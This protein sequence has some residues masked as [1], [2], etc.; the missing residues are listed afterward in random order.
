MYTST[1]LLFPCLQADIVDIS[2]G[3][4]QARPEDPTLE[5]LENPV[6]AVNPLVNHRIRYWKL[7]RVLQ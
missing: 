4:E 1:Y 5:A 2:N 6:T 7:Q 3:E